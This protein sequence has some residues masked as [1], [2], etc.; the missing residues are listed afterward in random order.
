MLSYRLDLLNRAAMFAYYAE[1]YSS[2]N[3][4]ETHNNIAY[5]ISAILSSFEKISILKSECLKQ[6][7]LFEENTKINKASEMINFKSP[8]LYDIF[9]NISYIALSLR[10][11]QNSILNI[12]SKEESK[13]KNKISLPNSM[14]DFMKKIENY[15]LDSSIKELI[16]TY[17]N[18]NG[19][20]LKDY[21]DI[22]EHHNYLI[23][24]VYI[25]NFKDKNLIL[26]LPDNPNVKSYKKYTFN[27][28]ID[29]FQFL[30]TEYIEIEKLLNL[31]SKYYNY[32]KGTFRYKFYIHH[33]NPNNMEIVYDKKNNTLVNMESYKNN[34]KIECQQ[35]IYD[36][37]NIDMEAFSFVKYPKFFDSKRNFLK[38]HEV[39]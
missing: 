3:L 8:S 17:W 39:I 31:I 26:L 11:I 37:N 34:L 13:Q 27:K 19:K 14:N 7:N 2:Y 28:N 22:D 32:K 29:A 6:F 20:L 15:S 16:S 33:E 30:L 38:I 24:K 35:L 36:P 12:I 5:R 18:S 10:I 4:D 1:W 9:V 21:R 25:D 23:D